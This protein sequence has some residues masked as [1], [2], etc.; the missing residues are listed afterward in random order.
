MYRGGSSWGQ[1]EFGNL[2][3]FEKG[4]DKIIKKHYIVKRKRRVT[5]R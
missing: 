1:K 5:G 4:I 3:L 2:L